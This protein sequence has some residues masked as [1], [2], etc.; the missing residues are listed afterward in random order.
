[1]NI[2][3]DMA[4]IIDRMGAMMD[5]EK[6]ILI[7]DDNRDFREQLSLHLLNSFKRNETTSLV[8]R[9]KATLHAS[10]QVDERD[11]TPEPYVIHTASQGEQAYEMVQEALRQGKPYAL[12]FLDIRMPPGWD[13]VITLEHIWKIDKKVQVVLCSA[14]SI[15]SWKE[16]VERFGKKDN[17][18]IL[19]KPFDTTVVSQIALALTEKYLI[20][21]NSG[22]NS[23]ECFRHIINGL[24]APLALV[25]RD[26]KVTHWNTAAE[27]FTKVKSPEVFG[28]LLWEVFAG[29][30][31]CGGDIKEVIATQED[32]SRECVIDIEGR[33]SRVDVTVYPMGRDSDNDAAIVRI[34]HKEEMTGA[35]SELEYLRT[36]NSI[37]EAI[38]ML[39]KDL[40]VGDA[41]QL[42]QKLRQDVEK[43]E[44]VAKD[45]EEIIKRAI[46]NNFSQVAAEI[47]SAV[48]DCHELLKGIE[49][50]T[51][52]GADNTACP[53]PGPQLKLCFW[54][55]LVNAAE[56]VKPKGMR[57]GRIEITVSRVNVLQPMI[58]LM[59][60]A[61]P[62]TYWLIKFT[63]NGTGMD[64][65]TVARIFDPFFSTKN[66]C[67]LGLV[68]VY[69]ILKQNG[70]HIMVE[71]EPGKG[72]CFSVYLPVAR[73]NEE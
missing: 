60:E 63:D 20:E 19:K 38:S 37:H 62:G 9:V 18:L 53:V 35:L 11:F 30:E 22:M 1:M 47:S 5:R 70:G 59:P 33:K 40:D 32:I 15:Y 29:L 49:V 61:E 66:T 14:H 27:E 24:P 26:G 13:G 2:E 31:K 44:L 8:E 51:E 4:L 50:V 71:S 36:I 42:R 58:G 68:L 23:E 52:I 10:A 48:K 73:D 3:T 46:E 39:K 28:R 67:G 54:N 16:V 72:S 12:I 41:G 7:V 21:Q 57:D 34:L 56:A 6:R 17:L 69:N 55:I 43:L 25:G 45:S 65:A 64:R